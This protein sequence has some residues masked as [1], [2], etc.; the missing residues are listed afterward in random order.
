MS[1]ECADT[2]KPA[3]TPTPEVI[4]D[5]GFLVERQERRLTVVKEGA[6]RLFPHFQHVK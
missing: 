1:W 2:P 6:M 5:G 4:V 3:S